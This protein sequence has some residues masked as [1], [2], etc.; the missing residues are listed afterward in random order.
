M[1]ILDR[2]PAQAGLCVRLPRRFA[3]GGQ[4]PRNDRGLCVCTVLERCAP[5]GSLRRLLGFRI[6]V[7]DDRDC[8]ACEAWFS[9]G[10]DIF[11]LRF[12]PKGQAPLKMTMCL[13]LG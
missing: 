11:R 6:G 9:F 12:A 2:S 13:D 8:A 3:P 1:M 4:A 5:V 7:R 10:G